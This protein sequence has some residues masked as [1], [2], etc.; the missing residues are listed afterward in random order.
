MTEL[1]G[2]VCLNACEKMGRAWH[3][4]MRG[5]LDCA[6]SPLRSEWHFSLTN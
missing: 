1:S 2:I 5:F 3:R 6:A 4:E